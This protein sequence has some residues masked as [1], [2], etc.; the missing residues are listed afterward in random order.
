MLSEKEQSFLNE[1]TLARVMHKEKLEEAQA[2]LKKTEE[3]IAFWENERD[4]FTMRQLMQLTTEN[5]QLMDKP[6]TV[7]LF[8]RTEWNKYMKGEGREAFSIFDS[9]LR[10]GVSLKN[11]LND[12]LWIEAINI[13]ECKLILVKDKA[14]LCVILRG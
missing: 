3:K 11:Q 10:T 13:E 8:T 2:A 9:S 4:N 1:L 6:I 14:R 12:A 5:A 7:A